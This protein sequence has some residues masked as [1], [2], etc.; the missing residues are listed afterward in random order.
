MWSTLS[1]VGAI[2]CIPLASPRVET[3]ARAPREAT[4]C[5]PG[6]SERA[7]KTPPRRPRT[8]PRS[9]TGSPRQ[10]HFGLSL[11][12]SL[13]SAPLP[14]PARQLQRPARRPRRS[15]LARGAGARFPSSKPGTEA[16]GPGA[17]LGGGEYLVQLLGGHGG[18]RRGAAGSGRGTRRQTLC[19][20][21]FPAWPALPAPRPAPGAVHGPASRSGRPVRAGGGGVVRRSSCATRPGRPR[22]VPGG[23]AEA[24]A[25]V[26]RARQGPDGLGRVRRRCGRCGGIRGS[27]SP[28]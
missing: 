27:R 14:P 13:V 26:H 10:Q 16:R 28:V 12:K 4:P 20:S 18:R 22:S 9:G 23:P 25:R 19:S 2:F 1:I 7:G 8:L 21:W 17:P 24:Q 11:S 3:A 15:P 6:S 5:P